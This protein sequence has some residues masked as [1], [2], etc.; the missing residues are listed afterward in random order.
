[1]KEWNKKLNKIVERKFV[2]LFLWAF[3]IAQAFFAIMSGRW[4]LGAV[5]AYVFCLL[6]YDKKQKENGEKGSEKGDSP[7]VSDTLE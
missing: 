1:M 3:F 2:I 4:E 6:F 5:S 7:S